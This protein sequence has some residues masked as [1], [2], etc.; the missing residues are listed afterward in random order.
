MNRWRSVTVKRLMPSLLLRPDSLLKET[1]KNT[2]EWK[3]RVQRATSL[4]RWAWKAYVREK[5]PEESSH[6]I[7]EDATRDERKSFSTNMKEFW[8]DYRDIYTGTV[9]ASSHSAV[10]PALE[11]SNLTRIYGQHPGKIDKDELHPCVIQNH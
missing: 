9:R 8:L 10:E 3:E 2:L 4:D 1:R 7:I 11:V 6:E 5:I